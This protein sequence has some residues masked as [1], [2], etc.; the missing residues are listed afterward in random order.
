MKKPERIPGRSLGRFYRDLHFPATL[1]DRGHGS[2]VAQ[3]TRGTGFDPFGFVL[4]EPGLEGLGSVAELGVAYPDAMNQPVGTFDSRGTE[5]RDDHFDQ[6][7]QDGDGQSLACF[8]VCSGAQGPLSV[9]ND[10]IELAI[11]LGISGIPADLANGSRL[12]D[13]PPKP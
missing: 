3:A 7:L 11:P 13:A 6:G 12:E 10:G 9:L 5:L 2:V 8:A 4:G 1:G